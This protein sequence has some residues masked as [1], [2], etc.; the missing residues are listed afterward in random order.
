MRDVRVR[1]RDAGRRVECEIDVVLD[2]LFVA[3]VRLHVV[4]LERHR[5]AELLRDADGAL[6]AVRHVRVV[7]DRRH[8]LQIAEQTW[9]RAGEAGRRPRRIRRIIRSSSARIAEP[10]QSLLIGRNRAVERVRREVGTSRDVVDRDDGDGKRAHRPQHVRVQ[11]VVVIETCAAA[12]HRVVGERI[13]KTEARLDVVRVLRPAR[14]LERQ[15]R[16]VLREGVHDQVITHAK[17]H[18]Q[19]LCDLPVV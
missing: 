18:R 5:R 12:Q 1:I 16:H 14:K 13:R 15:E 7:R 17:I 8:L 2:R 9:R 6:P 10:G 11:L 19:V 3:A 4:H